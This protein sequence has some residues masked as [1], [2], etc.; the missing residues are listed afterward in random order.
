MNNWNQLTQYDFNNTIILYFN[1]LVSKIKEEKSLQY[2]PYD[3][4]FWNLWSLYL[5]HFVYI[6]YKCAKVFGQKVISIYSS[7]SWFFEEEKE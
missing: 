1:F 3:F 2:I 7:F 4:L 5:F 6:D